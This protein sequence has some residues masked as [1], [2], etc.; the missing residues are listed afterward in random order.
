MPIIE[1]SHGGTK[2]EIRI[3]GLQPR[4]E[5]AAV[6]HIMQY[7]KNQCADL[8]EELLQFPKA[9]NDDASDSAAY[10]NQVV[11][12]NYIEEDDELLSIY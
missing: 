7:G 4:Y 11:E 10:Q 12:Y 9:V 2:K 1:L 5:N 6:F 8:E 3:E